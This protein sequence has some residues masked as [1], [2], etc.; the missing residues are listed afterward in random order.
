MSTQQQQ[1]RLR[2][3]AHGLGLNLTDEQSGKLLAYLDLLAKWN[4]VST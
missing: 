4:K 2:A 3:A 1:T